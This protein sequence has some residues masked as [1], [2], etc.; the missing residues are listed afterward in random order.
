MAYV[1]GSQ[2]LNINLDT[3][4]N[5][6]I[7]INKE[8]NKLIHKILDYDNDNDNNDRILS[9]VQ[10]ITLNGIDFTKFNIQKF[11]SDIIYAFKRIRKFKSINK[12][13]RVSEFIVNLNKKVL[14]Q[15]NLKNNKI[16]DNNNPFLDTFFSLFENVL[17]MGINE[18]IQHN[19]EYFLQITFDKEKYGDLYKLFDKTN[20]QINI[21]D[22]FGNNSVD[23]ELIISILNIIKFIKNDERNIYLRDFLS[24]DF[25]NIAEQI[26]S[27]EKYLLKY[28]SIINNEK[29]LYK[30]NI[31]NPFLKKYI[32]Y[33]ILYIDIEKKNNYL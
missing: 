4:L 28:L 19:I 30:N 21:F 15:Y 26:Y 27:N 32:N 2:S 10:N 29:Y 23:S 7:N 33:I 1:E 24:Y 9:I 20:N 11:N 22:F 13:K 17:N 3:N 8:L 31:L 14:S 18:N 25:E 16:I 5:V 12:K 6:D